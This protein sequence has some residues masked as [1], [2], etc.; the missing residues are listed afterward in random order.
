MTGIYDDSEAAVTPYYNLQD[1]NGE[2]Q[3]SAVYVNMQDGNGEQQVWPVD[4]STSYM[5]DWD[6]G[7]TNWSVISSTGSLGTQSTDPVSSANNIGSHNVPSDVYGYI[8]RSSAGYTAGENWNI[9]TQTDSYYQLYLRSGGANA[10]T[11]ESQFQ[12][13]CQQQGAS[14]P[15][16][17]YRVAIFNSADEADL[18]RYDS[19]GKS[20]LQVNGNVTVDG[21]EWCLLEIKT[22]PS[23]GGTLEA[24]IKNVSTGAGPWTLSASDP[25]ALGAGGVRISTYDGNGENQT[26]MDGLRQ[27][28]GFTI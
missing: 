3:P 13:N 1:G 19:S 28:S 22:P 6:D 14:S 8:T 11:A 21:T 23:G 18:D 2:Q 7:T 17:K 24:R 26:H 12:F 4:T 25:D 15:D 16:A 5:E 10:G 20:T 27:I 9:Q